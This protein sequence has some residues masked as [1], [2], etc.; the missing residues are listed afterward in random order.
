MLTHKITSSK[1]ISYSLFDDSNVETVVKNQN[2]PIELWIAKDASV[3]VYPFGLINVLDRNGSLSNSSFIRG[4]KLD[5]SNSSLH[6]QFK[7][8]NTKS[9]GYLSIC[10]DSVSIRN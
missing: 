3:P 4:L 9:I 7:P 1:S 5:G 6:I 2:E 10:F 8:N